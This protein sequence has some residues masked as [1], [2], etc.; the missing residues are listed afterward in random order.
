[1]PVSLDEH[2]K[3][4]HLDIFVSEAKIILF[5]TR[6]VNLMNILRLTWALAWKN[7]KVKYKNSLLGFFWSLLNPLL[8][9]LIFS[10]IF[11]NAFS[12]IQNYKLYALSGLVIW[13]FF[14]VASNQ[15]IGSLIENGSVLKSLNIPPLIF[16]YSALVSSVINF[17]LTLIPFTALLFM[18]GFKPS[19]NLLAVPLL[20]TLYFIF[21]FGFSLLLCATN[22][23]FRDVGLLWNTIVPA[24]F[25]FTPIAYPPHLIPAKYQWI[26]ELNPLFHFTDMFRQMIY[27]NQMPPLQEWIRISI[28]SVLAVA[29][30]GFIF[31]MLKRGFFAHY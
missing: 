9:L 26:I 19:L 3:T 5:L 11:G 28:I 27:G 20:L 18:F 23:Y 13:S 15:V 4:H 21:T 10:F 14:P 7:I 6:I 17:I 16:T 22:V 12:D 8:F 29:F 25:Y 24:L 1:M 30:G 31:R 2:A